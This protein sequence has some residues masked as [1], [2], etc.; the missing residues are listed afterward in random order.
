MLFGHYI[1]CRRWFP[2]VI[3]NSGPRLLPGCTRSCVLLL[4]RG[5]RE[6]KNHL[7]MS[8]RKKNLPSVI[9]K[10]QAQQTQFESQCWVAGMALSAPFR[11]ITVQTTYHSICLLGSVP[12]LKKFPIKQCEA[13]S[14]NDFPLLSSQPRVEKSVQG[15]DIHYFGHPT[16][17][18]LHSDRK[19]SWN[20]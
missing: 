12:E 20:Q 4:C 9:A 6:S 17:L 13:Q 10:V 2:L 18:C 14:N 5:G 15:W 16:L 19:I 3:F 11:H 1:S 8:Q 7:K